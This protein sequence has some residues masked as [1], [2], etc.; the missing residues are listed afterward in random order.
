MMKLCSQVAGIDQN[1][2]LR[3][4]VD[5]ALELAEVEVHGWGRVC[6]DEDPSY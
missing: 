2:I 1:H 5:N 6:G 3:Y 4:Q